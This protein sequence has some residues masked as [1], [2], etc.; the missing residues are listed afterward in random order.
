MKH[1][2]LGAA[3]TGFHDWYWQR[4]SAVILL[5]L[6]PIPIILI[7]LRYAGKVDATSLNQ[8]LTHPGVKAIFSLLIISISLHVWTGLKVIFE[9][10]IHTTSG[11]VLLV[12]IL[13]AGIL[14]MSIYGL[15]FIWAEAI[16][17]LPS[18]TYSQGGN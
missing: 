6:F 18:I 2:D 4:I 10:Y 14:V 5:L 11:R 8:W 1:Q 7:W 13:L 16:N 9:D 17:T 12:N 3:Q 15:Y